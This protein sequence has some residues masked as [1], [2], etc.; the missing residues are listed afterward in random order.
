MKKIFTLLLALVMCFALAAC[1][2]NSGGSTDGG[3][4]DDATKEA[5]L[6]NAPA[7]TGCGGLDEMYEVLRGNSYQDIAS[8]LSGLCSVTYSPAMIQT[9]IQDMVDYLNGRASRITV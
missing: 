6:S 4:I 9:A 5:F 3:G 2:G 8:Q 1:G 7:I